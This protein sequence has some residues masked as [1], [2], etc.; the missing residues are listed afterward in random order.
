VV[1]HLP[2]AAAHPWARAAVP[3]AGALRPLAWPADDRVA[4]RLFPP[5]GH[6]PVLYPGTAAPAAPR[7]TVAG[8]PD[9]ASQRNGP[10]PR[11]GAGPW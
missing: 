11:D 3:P 10:S 1:A 9:G 5:A 8:A 6:G 7:L 2:R 4:G